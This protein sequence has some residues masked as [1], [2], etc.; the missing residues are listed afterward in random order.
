MK[1]LLITILSIAFVLFSAQGEEREVVQQL[2][3][4]IPFVFNGYTEEEI[5]YGCDISSLANALRQLQRM[6]CDSTLVIKA[7][8]FYSSVSPEGSYQANKIVS[9]RRL[10]SA[11]RII[12]NYISIPESAKI[13]RTERMIPWSEYLLP[14]IAADTTRSYRD[15]LVRLIVEN[16]PAKRRS[17]LLSAK[18]GELWRMV[19]QDHF[20]YM[21]KAGAVITAARVIYS[22][23]ATTAP[24]AIAG[25]AA[26]DI[27]A[28]S[29]P[30]KEQCRLAESTE[31]HLGFSLKSNL[32]AWGLGV[33]NVAIEFDLCKHLS[34]SLPVMYSAYN[35]FKST[36][37]F[38][39]LATQPELRYWIK[40][41]NTGLFVGAHF[42]VGSYN[43]AVNKDT[44]YQDHNGDSPAL[45]GGLS[46]GY[47]THIS[48][49]KRWNMEFV[50][51]AGCYKLYYDT[52]YNVEN[53][54]L[55]GTHK[56]TYWGVDN[57]AINFNYR[58]DYNNKQ[59]K[60]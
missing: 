50:V 48:K 54:C 10:A 6:A 26:V 41:E 11:E 16:E 5:C 3:I 46:I 28:I 34:L 60:R 37:K 1:K 4:D 36:I 24:T 14:A 8:E 59:H 13:T 51:G 42:G 53:G 35:Y 21:R 56:R 25:V 18:G 27:E 45:G 47:R 31:S 15:E 33:T 7:V 29:L 9:K 23:I 58:F 17:A 52:F 38:R 2:A 40:K 44:R 19:E 43:I 32:V 55:N 49:N 57:A 39:T 22:P 12:R 20:K 30:R